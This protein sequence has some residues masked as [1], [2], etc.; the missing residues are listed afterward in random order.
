MHSILT[1]SSPGEPLPEFPPRTHSDNPSDRLKPFTRP[2]DYLRG[3]PRNSENHDIAGALARAGNGSH[4]PWDGTKITKAITCNGGENCGLY[5]GSRGMTCREFAAMQ[6]FPH[7]HVFY[8][9][10]IRKQIGNAVPPKFAKVLFG[11]IRIHLERVDVVV[12]EVLVLE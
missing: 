6:G 3:I 11:W 12:R 7:Y 5:D 10:A 8:G 4:R 9:N 2:I 1:V